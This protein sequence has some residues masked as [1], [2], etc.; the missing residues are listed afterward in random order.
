MDIMEL[1]HMDEAL[2]DDEQVANAVGM[3]KWYIDTASNTH[4]VGDKRYFIRYRGLSRDE[5][6][7]RGVAPSFKE[8][9]CGVETILL[10]TSVSGNTVHS[11][12]DDVLLVPGASNPL[13][14]MERAL[15]DLS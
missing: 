3:Q 15:E 13:L 5:A 4:V 2:H 9:P 1:N 12:I 10:E 11:V 6:T 8:Q 14:S 7:V